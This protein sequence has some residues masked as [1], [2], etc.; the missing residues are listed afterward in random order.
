MEQTDREILQNLLARRIGNVVNETISGREV[1][2]DISISVMVESPDYYLDEKG[3]GHSGRL[4]TVV[5]D[6]MEE[7]D[8]DED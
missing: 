8:D 2:G 3:N 1:D 7:S 5:V 4:I 6:F